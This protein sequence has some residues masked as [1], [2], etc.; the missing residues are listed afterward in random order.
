MNPRM[1]KRLDAID[2]ALAPN[3]DRNGVMFIPLK[4]ET[5]EEMDERMARWYAGE[6]VE[7][8]DKLYTGREWVVIR[9]KYVKAKCP[10]SIQD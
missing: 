2:L 9:I 10:Q 8:Q 5:E 4:G 6:K 7:G 1:K 3:E